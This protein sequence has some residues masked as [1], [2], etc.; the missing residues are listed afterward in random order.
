MQS[1]SEVSSK[2]TSTGMGVVVVAVCFRIEM[3][4]KSPG[5]RSHEIKNA[6]AGTIH[7]RPRLSFSIHRRRS[8]GTLDQKMETMKERDDKEEREDMVI[9]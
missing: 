7:R 6:Q 5:L 8:E 1:C 9:C 2:G 4:A 3:A